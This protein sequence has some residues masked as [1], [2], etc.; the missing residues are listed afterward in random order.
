ATAT[1]AAA[2]T[3][4]SSSIAFL[5]STSSRTVILPSE[6][7]TPFTSVA[8]F[9]TPPLP[10]PVS[11]ARWSVQAHLRRLIQLRPN[12]TG[13]RR[14]LPPALQAARRLPHRPALPHRQPA[15]PM[16]PR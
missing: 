14:G 16:P 5:S 15:P 9:P 7:R 3:P 11:L 6:S 13:A 2:V 12:Q 1:G 4:H 10:V 8:I